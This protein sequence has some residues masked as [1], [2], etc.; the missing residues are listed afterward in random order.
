MKY[1][2][3]FFHWLL[4][5]RVCCALPI[6]CHLV[7]YLGKLHY[8]EYLGVVDVGKWRLRFWVFQGIG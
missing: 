6:I 4:L 3:G 5:W 7:K 1:N 2:G 8:Y